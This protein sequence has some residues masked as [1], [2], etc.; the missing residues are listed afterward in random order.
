MPTATAQKL[1]LL[2]DLRMR[3]GAIYWYEENE[4][5]KTDKEKFAHDINY[6]TY[7]LNSYLAN[8]VTMAEKNATDPH[9]NVAHRSAQW[10]DACFVRCVHY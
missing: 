8:P 1:P 7:D 6:Y 10:S 2:H 4:F 9:T 5:Y 3:K